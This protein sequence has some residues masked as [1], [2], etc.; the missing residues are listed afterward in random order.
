MN[1][2]ISAAWWDNKRSSGAKYFFH[3]LKGGWAYEEY[4]KPLAN[5]GNMVDLAKKWEVNIYDF[6]RSGWNIK[7]Q[8]L[9]ILNLPFEIPGHES[10][11]YIITWKKRWEIEVSKEILFEKIQEEALK[12]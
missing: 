8:H 6:T 12:R 11:V 10:L 9:L 7:R 5:I 1:W 3:L 2:L 4:E